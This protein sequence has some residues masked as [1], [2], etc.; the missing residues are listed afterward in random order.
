MNLV[1]GNGLIGSHLYARLKRTTDKVIMTSR[2]EIDLSRDDWNLP[3]CEVAY[4]CAAETSTLKCEEFP[5]ETRKINVTNT[6]KLAEK[7]NRSDK[8]VWLSS[9]RVFDGTRPYITLGDEVCP[10]TEYGRQKAEAE[11]RLLKMGVTVIRLSK[12]LGWDVSL[13]EG[14]IKDLKEGKTIYPYSNVSMSPL[15]VSLVAEVIARVEGFF[16]LS[17]GRDLAYSQVAYF[18][19]LYLG[20]DINLVQPIEAK[21]SHRYTTLQTDITSLGM[22][23]PNV[24]YTIYQ[25]CEKRYGLFR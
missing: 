21:E 9:E 17:A 20:V 4:I 25:W 19:A 8:I 12:V 14:W 5:E 1:I 18:M 16:Q 23:V 6:I 13:F 3:R 15:P 10:T 7:L 2:E 24:W 22:W 11:K